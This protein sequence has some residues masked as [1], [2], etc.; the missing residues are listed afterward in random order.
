MTALL[1]GAAGVAAGTWVGGWVALP[2]AGAFAGAWQGWRLRRNASTSRF[3]GPAATAALAGTAGW[4]VLLLAGTV[5]GPVAEVAHLAGGVL[6]GLP[7]AAFFAVTLLFAGLLA[8]TG[9]GAAGA[10][11]QLATNAAPASRQGA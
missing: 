2:V 3:R 1:L 7:G 6:G 5:R 11:V 9:G 4:A 8:G 10:L